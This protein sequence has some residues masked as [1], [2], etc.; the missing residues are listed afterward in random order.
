M[1]ESMLVEDKIVGEI[2]KDPFQPVCYG[3]D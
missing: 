1:I 3:M 2:E